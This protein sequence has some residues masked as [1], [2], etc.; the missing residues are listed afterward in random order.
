M[1]NQLRV[2]ITA[3]EDSGLSRS[4][5]G[6]PSSMSPANIS[7]EQGNRRRCPLPQNRQVHLSGFAAG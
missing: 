6:H 5:P 2:Q 4:E 7:P 1:T 3:A